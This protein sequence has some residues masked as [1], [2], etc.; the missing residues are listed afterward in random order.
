VGQCSNSTE[1]RGSVAV[2]S[3]NDIKQFLAKAGWGQADRSGLAGDASNRRYERLELNSTRRILM[4]VPPDKDDNIRSFV[5]ITNILRSRCLSAPE[6]Y[7]EDANRGLVL[8]EDLGD[9]LFARLAKDSETEAQMYSAAVGLLPTLADINDVTNI[10]PY[11][12][13]TYQREARLILDWYI[14][15]ATGR[16]ADAEAEAEFPDLI[17]AACA[18]ARTGTLVLR[19]YHA[20]N[21]L[22]LPNREGH[23]KVGLLDY[24]DA[25]MGDAAYDLV[26]LLE[27]ARR[28]VSKNLQD[29]EIKHY[30]ALTGDTEADF[31]R[32]YAA[33][34]AQRNIKI[35]GIFARLCVRDGKARY[36]DFIPRVWLYLQQDLQH[37][38]LERLANWLARHVPVPTSAII[39]AVKAGKN[40]A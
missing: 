8:I 38:A 25:M 6:I 10:P 3:E 9:D 32:R 28:D 17:A 29:S 39:A 33:L 11:D 4:I 35:V 20:E 15:S 7:A 24:Q 31:L 27:D 37:P 21:L 13:A 36:P 2:V 14:P 12:M 1:R 30:L 22:W 18:P 40:A 19:D 26:S 34:G 5:H 16:P 23:Q